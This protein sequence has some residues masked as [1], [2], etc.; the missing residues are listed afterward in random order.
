MARI[1]FTEL[2]EGFEPHPPTPPCTSDGPKSHEWTLTVN[3]GAVHLSSDCESCNETVLGPCGG[4]DVMMD[5]AVICSMD[6]HTEVYGWETP[7]YDHWWVLT[8]V[9]I[10]AQS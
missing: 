2:P 10:E 3:E 7:E 4:D 6:D 9:R 1:E 8:P 5:A